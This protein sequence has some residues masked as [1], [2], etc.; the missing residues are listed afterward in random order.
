MS[1]GSAQPTVRQLGTATAELHSLAPF[2]TSSLQVLNYFLNELAYNPGGKDQGF[3][4][5]LPWFAHNG[6]SA[7]PLADGNGG[8]ARAAV[9]VNC[10]QIS[11]AAG[12]LAPLFA[13]LLGTA[14]LCKSGS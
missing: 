7:F 1:P 9:Y 10:S 14:D 8:I 12:D 2:M 4:F 6:A 13:A 3:L 5:W 11:G